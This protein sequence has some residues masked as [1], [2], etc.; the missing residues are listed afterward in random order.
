MVDNMTKPGISHSKASVCPTCGSDVATTWIKAPD[1]AGYVYTCFASY[2]HDK[3][4]QISWVADPLK[5][6]DAP[7]GWTTE[8]ITTNL[9]D[10]ILEIL[11]GLPPTW[12]EYGVIEYQLFLDYPDLFAQ[13]VAERGHVI[14]GQWQATASSVRFPTALQRLERIGAVT[15]KF[16]TATG[17]W[18]YNQEVSYWA[19][20]PEPESGASPLTWAQRAVDLGRV[21]ADEWSDEDRTA[22]QALVAAHNAKI[23]RY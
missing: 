3:E 4:G 20:V 15:H 13:H 9:V 10:P 22:I 2:A 6:G 7:T 17:E 16:D 8:G 19:L 23:Q 1:G 5:G 14:T 18:G 21:V 11:K 12:I